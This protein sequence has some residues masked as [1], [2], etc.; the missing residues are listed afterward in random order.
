MADINYPDTLPDFKFGKSRSQV[1]TYRTSQPFAGPMYIEQ[2]TDQSPVTW[3]VT[4][5]CTND[6]QARQFQAFLRLVCQ[7]QTFNK[8]IQTEEGHIEH[9]VRFIDMPLSPTQ[10]GPHQWQYSGTIIAMKLIQPDADI[11]NE[12]LL[13]CRLQEASCIDQ[14]MNSVW[15][16]N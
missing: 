9:E 11:C 1:Q 3:D 4:L 8:C 10:K 5:D 13:V 16:E 6:I 15:P 2:I 7:G 12:E 14:V